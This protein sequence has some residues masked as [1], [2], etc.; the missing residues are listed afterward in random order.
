MIYPYLPKSRKILYVKSENKFMKEATKMLAKSGC[1]KQSTSAVIFRKG[2]FLGRGVNA[3]KKVDVCPR[4]EKGCPTGT[5][6]E[7]CREVCEQQGHAEIMAIKNA[8][9]KGMNLEGASLY[10]DGHWWICEE[11]WDAIIEAK[12]SKV[13][14]RI[15][16]MELYR[17]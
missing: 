8:K 1:A 13:Y 15:D 3:G 17:R 9:E 4:V 10:L 2:N 12:I 5:G 14:L 11:C 7:L 16:S 6:Y